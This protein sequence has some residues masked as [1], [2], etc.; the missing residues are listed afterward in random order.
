MPNIKYIPGL[1]PLRGIAALLVILLHYSMFVTTVIPA[2]T[3]PII[4][5]LYLMVDLFFVL[6]GFIMYHVYGGYFIAGASFK[7]IGGFL[8]ARFAR[9]YPLH[10]AMLVMMIGLGALAYSSNALEGP[11]AVV[12][13]F[14]AIPSQLLLTQAMGTHHE[15]TFNTPSW[16]IS[17]EW[18]AYVLFPFLML[19]LARTKIWTRFVFITLIAFAYWYIMYHMQPEFWA[20]RW[21]Q[22]GYPES[23]PYPVHIIDVI[24]GAPAFLRCLCGFIWGMLVYELFSNNWGKSVLKSGRAFIGVWMVLL[25]LWHFEVMVDPFAVLL[26]GI[27]ILAA[28]YNQDHTGRILNNKILNYMGDISYSLYLVH[29]PIIT[30]FLFGRAMMVNPDP[31]KLAMGYDFPPWISWLGLLAMYLISIGVA[32]LTYRY[33]EKLARNYLRKSKTEKTALPMN[34]SI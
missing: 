27:M 24:T 31:L 34:K 6:S 12:F 21:E 7:K 1:T 20:I 23:I 3:S 11:L 9:I 32:T 8:R 13:D 26:F 28:A 25:V 4:S 19:L 33:I 16:S 15:A 29:V 22:F 5:K 2:E 17:V 14:T 18:W 10:L 30:V